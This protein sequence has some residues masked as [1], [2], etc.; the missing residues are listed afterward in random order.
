[1]SVEMDGTARWFLAAS[2]S[3]TNMRTC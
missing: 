1:M 2:R 3:G